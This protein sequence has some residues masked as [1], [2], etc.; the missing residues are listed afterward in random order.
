MAKDFVDNHR[1]EAIYLLAG[2][3]GTAGLSTAG[4]YSYKN[5]LHGKAITKTTNA[6]KWIANQASNGT[7]TVKGWFTRGTTETATKKGSNGAEKKSIGTKRRHGSILWMKKEGDGLGDFL[8]SAGAI[9][10]WAPLPNILVL[11]LLVQLKFSTPAAR[12]K[13]P[14]I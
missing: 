10:P 6:G 1:K 2:I 14:S 7:K 5:N 3:A 11:P 4:Y 8:I 9:R 13:E 12:G